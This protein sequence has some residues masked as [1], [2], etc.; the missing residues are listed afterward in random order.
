MNINHLVLETVPPGSEG[1]QSGNA[2]PGRTLRGSRQTGC[3]GDEWDSVMNYDA[4]HGA[5]DL[6]PDRNGKTQRRRSAW[7]FWEMRITL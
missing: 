7:T 4:L 6:V 5:G 1:R 3:R 2:D